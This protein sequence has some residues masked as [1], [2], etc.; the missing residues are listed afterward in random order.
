MTMSL[1][2]PSP[3]ASNALPGGIGDAGSVI[4]P[5]VN[6]LPVRFT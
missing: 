3:T 2:P 4:P 5:Y 1:G 6:F